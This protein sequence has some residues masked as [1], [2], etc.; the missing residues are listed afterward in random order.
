MSSN[1]NTTIRTLHD[2]GGAAWFGGALM[3][4][5]ALNGASA[6]VKDPTER[7]RIAADGWGRWSPVAVGAIGAHLLGGIGLIVAN[8][9]R[10]KDQHGVGAN[11][12]VKTV[13]TLAAVGSTAYSGV[14]GAQLANHAGEPAESGTVP[15]DRTPADVA[16]VQNKLR[17]MQWVTPALTGVLVAL[18][19]QQGEQQ[20]AGQVLTGKVAR[21]LRR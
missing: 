5:V 16:K 7:S 10:V 15:S 13:L 11:T 21:R 20:K 4:A 2:V 8:R 18:G 6:D 3:G 17:V 14:L 19:A 12:V 1:R 9:D